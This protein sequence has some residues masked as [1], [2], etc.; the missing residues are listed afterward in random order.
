M[1]ATTAS[2][3]F[4][5]MP[6]R[7]PHRPLFLA[8]RHAESDCAHGG[9]GQ[10][11]EQ[12]RQDARRGEPAPPERKAA[13]AQHDRSRYVSPSAAQPISQGVAPLPRQRRLRGR[14]GL[15]RHVHI[16]HGVSPRS[17]AVPQQVESTKPPISSGDAKTTD[18]RSPIMPPRASTGLPFAGPLAL[19]SLLKRRLN[20]QKGI[21]SPASVVT[22]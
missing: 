15:R 16:V 2:K 5:P 3:P 21:V 7:R 12:D 1:P 14:G 22:K 9:A 17:R 11:G 18:A 4:M 6:P 19:E 8:F 13:A 20:S 10:D